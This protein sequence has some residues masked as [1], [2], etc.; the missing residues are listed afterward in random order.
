MSAPRSKP[1]FLILG[2]SFVH[3]LQSF[4]KAR[5]EGTSTDFGLPQACDV[6]FLGR[7][8]RRVP[9][10][11]SEL[12]NISTIAPDFVILD[13]ATNDLA[14]PGSCPGEIA[15]SVYFFAQHLVREFDVK[16]VHIALVFRRLSSADD[17]TP[18]NSNDIVFSYNSALRS[19]CDHG[20]SRSM[21]IFA[22]YFQ[23]MSSSWENFLD[24]LDGAHFN[25][26]PSAGC[27]FSGTFKYYK[28]IKTCIYLALRSLPVSN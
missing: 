23:G 13:I 18:A 5:R 21:P 27:S 11:W 22:F 1:V 24:P 6:V 19:L 2:H 3:R 12:D 26:S 25:T 10:L 15:D 20:F 16:A 17:R 28:S 9:H 7:G 4:C 8:G 14:C